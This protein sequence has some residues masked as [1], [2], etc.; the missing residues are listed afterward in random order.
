MKNAVRLGMAK[1]G[2]VTKIVGQDLW[3]IAAKSDGPKIENSVGSVASVLARRRGD[4]VSGGGTPQFEY[5]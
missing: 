4:S 5:R 3:Y 1:M 2:L